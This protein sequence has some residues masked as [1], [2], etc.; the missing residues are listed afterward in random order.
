MNEAKYN[1]EACQECSRLC[2]A[3]ANHYQ[4]R[5]AP[6]AEMK[7]IRL[8]LDCAEICQTATEF[9]PRAS[10]LHL[11]ICNACAVICLKCGAFCEG[12]TEDALLQVCAASCR[13]SA[14]ACQSLVASVSERKVI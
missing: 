12:F 5:G 11:T 4:K 13:R 1:L 2:L 7:Y 14:V 3:L 6:Q 8:L 10:A 9:L